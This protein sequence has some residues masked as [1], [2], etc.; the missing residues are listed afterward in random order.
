MPRF[1]FFYTQTDCIFRL[2]HNTKQLFDVFEAVTRCKMHCQKNP[3]KIPHWGN[4]FKIIHFLF[5]F[6]FSAA[7]AHLTA[8]THVFPSRATFSPRCSYKF[9]DTETAVPVIWQTE[10]RLVFSFIVT[11]TQKHKKA[12]LNQ[13]YS[14]FNRKAPYWNIFQPK[15]ASDQVL[16]V[17]LIVSEI[18]LRTRAVHSSMVVLSSSSMLY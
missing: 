13:P 16:H 14:F 4:I 2:Q 9:K 5:H 8:L 7:T 17:F 18:W 10:K 6:V 11:K 15:G 1:F 12:A 3:W